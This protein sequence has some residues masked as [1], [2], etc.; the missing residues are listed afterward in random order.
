MNVPF[1]AQGEP[2]TV[3]QA[4]DNMIAIL[5]TP[6]GKVIIVLTVGLVALR[7]YYAIRKAVSVRA[8]ERLGPPRGFLSGYFAQM[9]LDKLVKARR[10]E[11][12][13]DLLQAW[14]P[15]RAIEAAELYI[16]AKKYVRAAAILVANNR[17]R[18]AAETY[19]RAGSFD[20]AAELFER[21]E[22]LSSAEDN[23]LRAGN[24]LAAARMLAKAG[25]PEKAA[26]YFADAERPREAAEQLE[27]A[28]KTREAV[29]KYVEA[30]A[31]LE[32]AGS[33]D[34]G[35]H[36]RE[37]M[38]GG[39]RMLDQ[40]CD[41]ILALYEKL[42]DSESQVELLLERERP[43]EAAA[44]LKKSGDYKTAA[45]ILVQHDMVDDAVKALDE[46][47]AGATT[48]RRVLERQASGTSQ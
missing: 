48:R 45:E 12:A 20:L 32:R 18:R 29:E 11:E 4:I 39:N 40:L 42:G 41:K 36:P 24:K 35:A 46:G 7:I 3:G 25:K 17:L 34:R 27:K 22:D 43:A 15:G 19:V 1:L 26:R 23:Y 6:P 31:L 14:Q 28:G 33:F 9:R 47:G 30:L 16:K 21:A 37:R 8:D 44:V 2:V 38:M 10:Y 13:A 5:E